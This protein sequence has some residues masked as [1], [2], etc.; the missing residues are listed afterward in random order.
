M[1]DMVD[2]NDARRTDT[3]PDIG[4]SLDATSSPQTLK[5]EKNTNQKMVPMTRPIMI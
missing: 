5:L 1:Y 4:I 3:L 2:G